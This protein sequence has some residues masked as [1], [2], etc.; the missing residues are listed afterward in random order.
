[1]GL[2]GSQNDRVD[3]RGR[4]KR[5]AALRAALR[6][7]SPAFPP[8]RSIQLQE[9][10]QE[11]S[12][13]L[14]RA[15]YPEEQAAAAAQAPLHAELEGID[16]EW[17]EF[18]RELLSLISELPLSQIRATL[19]AVQESNP[20]E[21]LAL[22][23]LC[24][25]DERAP[26]ER[27]NLLD[28]IVTLASTETDAGR[29]RVARDPATLT[30]AL[31]ALCTET[32]ERAADGLDELVSEFQGAC[33]QITRGEPLT[34][35][36]ARLRNAKTAS[37][38]RLLAPEVLRAVIA[39]NVALWNRLEELTEADR[40]LA[41]AERRGLDSQRAASEPVLRPA[42][43]VSVFD[44][45]GIRTLEEAI[46][47]RLRGS[48]TAACGAADLLDRLDL[49]S[50]SRIEEMA[51]GDWEDE[52]SARVVRVAGVVGLIMRRLEAMSQSLAEIGVTAEI[53][54][55]GWIPEI[56]RELL[57]ATQEC[58]SSRAGAT[59]AA[60]LAEVQTRFLRTASEQSLWSEAEPEDEAP[61]PERPATA[62]RREQRRRPREGRQP[63]GATRR[64]IAL[65][66][67]FCL[68]TAAVLLHL[69]INNKQT[70]L[71]Y[72]AAQVAEISPHL[73]S[74]YRS[75]FGYGPLLIG[76][77]KDDWGALSSAERVAIGK[78]IGAKL[79][80]DGIDEVMLFDKRRRLEI[81]YA[82]QKLRHAAR[83]D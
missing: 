67:G 81:H 56:A 52:R 16:R 78:E 31:E 26:S 76:T 29:R 59:D 20:Q 3:V 21:V 46:G 83:P 66:A 68:V 18:S 44:S 55:E 43:C 79:R 28:Y 33:E 70:V 27:W 74:A 39:C 2:E 22:L 51:F 17:A 24:I 13:R 77:L 65:A 73:D 54:R 37:V 35:V 63:D 15:A 1:M 11:L 62:P 30:P 23:D 72:S 64:R 32:S 53:L 5:Y 8:E 61:A 58:L 69:W 40:T 50:L 82:H 25:A 60:R 75:A 34:P 9:R 10:V 45:E 80:F 48:E 38:T 47:E 36:R 14:R 7:V 71:I 49:P 6:A 57:A 12:S 41:A 42:P 19:P 4:L